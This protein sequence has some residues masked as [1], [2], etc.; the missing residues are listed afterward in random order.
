MF[1]KLFRFLLALFSVDT[2]SIQGTY[3]ENVFLSGTRE[4]SQSEDACAIILQVRI[5][6]NI[7]LI[8]FIL[9]LFYYYYYYC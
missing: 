3:R 1:S 2:T 4:G 6:Q 7:F 5:V 8:N 9:F